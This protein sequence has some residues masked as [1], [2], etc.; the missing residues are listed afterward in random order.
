MFNYKWYQTFLK[1][2]PRDETGQKLRI[3]LYVR[4]SVMSDRNEASKVSV[5]PERQTTKILWRIQSLGSSGTPW[6]PSVLNPGLL[7][8]AWEANRW[9]QT[10]GDVFTF[11]VA[12]HAALLEYTQLHNAVNMW[13]GACRSVSVMSDTVTHVCCVTLWADCGAGGLCSSR[14]VLDME[15]YN[16]I[17]SLL[18]IKVRRAFRLPAQICFL[19]S[20][21]HADR[22][23]ESLD[24]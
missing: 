14:Q 22:L 6:K 21:V 10:A 15:K 4:F 23:Q 24:N 16:V 11:S 2:W 1:L 18:C 12:L 5:D 20:R 8:S 7:V 3:P 17:L 13:R 9:W 19:A